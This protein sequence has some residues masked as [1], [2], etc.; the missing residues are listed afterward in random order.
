MYAQHPYAFTVTIIALVLLVLLLMVLRRRP[1]FAAEVVQARASVSAMRRILVPIRG[2][3]HEERAVELACRLGEEQKSHI[4]LVYVIEVPLS[5]SL[6][7]EM[8]DEDR[9][10]SEALRRSVEVVKAHRLAPVPRVERDR[11]AGKGI[12]RVA[13]E[14]GVDAVV[15]GLDPARSIAVDP[16]GPTTETL[17]RRAGF[18]VIVDRPA[19]LAD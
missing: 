3:R 11:D 10:A 9:R 14:L 18:E 5:L 12:L 2:F 6:G 16:I 17:L 13:A 7:T 8:P 15:I 19:P 4:Y 1:R